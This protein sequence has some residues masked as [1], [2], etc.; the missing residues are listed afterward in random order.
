MLSPLSRHFGEICET[1]TGSIWLRNATA[2]LDTGDQKKE[3]GSGREGDKKVKD[4]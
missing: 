4:D 2:S 1:G 3:P